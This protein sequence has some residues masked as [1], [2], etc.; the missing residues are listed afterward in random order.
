MR[1]ITLKLTD[2]Q[3]NAVLRAIEI[4]SGILRWNPAEQKFASP[5]LTPDDSNVREAM[6][7]VHTIIESELFPPPEEDVAL[8]EV[9]VG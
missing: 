6:R 9:A 7:V 3:A 4:S 8:R 1:R 2:D 5:V